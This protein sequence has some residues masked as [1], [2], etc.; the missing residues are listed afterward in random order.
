MREVGAYDYKNTGIYIASTVLLLCA[1][2]VNPHTANPLIYSPTS[3]T[4]PVYEGAN[5]FILRRILH[6]VP[7]HSP[8]HPTRVITTFLNLDAVTGVL[9]AVGAAKFAGNSIGTSS[10]HLGQSLMKAALLLQIASMALFVG[11]AAKFHRN[12][13]RGGVCNQKLKSVFVVL[14]CSCSIITVRTIYRTAEYFASASVSVLNTQSSPHTRSPI[15]RHEWFF[16][17]FEASLMLGNSILLNVFYP[18]RHIPS[19][20]KIYL[21]RDG[22]TEIEGPGFADKGERKPRPL[23]VALLDPLDIVGLIRGKDKETGL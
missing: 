4:S 17:V 15:F 5:Y 2:L 22:V 13:R 11:V 14:Y 16:W 20:D 8:L 1:P 7:Y 10:H 3:P 12:C 23:I 18:L 19:S 6:Y 21:S 9:T